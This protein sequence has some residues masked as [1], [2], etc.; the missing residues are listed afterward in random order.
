MV[1]TEEVAEFCLNNNLTFNQFFGIEKIIGSLDL[2]KVK[3]LPKGFEPVIE[4]SLYLNSLKSI[5]Y[6]TR[7][8]VS[9]RLHLPS[10]RYL[11]TDCVLFVLGTIYL[12]N[13]KSIPSRTTI[14]TNTVLDIMNCIFITDSS[15][16]ISKEYI[17]NN[18]NLKINNVISF[19]KL[20][21]NL[22]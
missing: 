18:N 5:E 19:E 1:I 13:L 4:G 20:V 8:I 6:K 14:V 17:I 12:S 15:V 10:L 22:K 16:I 3:H 9:E 11:C 21:D 7:F 2:S